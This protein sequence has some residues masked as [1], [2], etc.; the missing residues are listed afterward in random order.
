MQ[1]LRGSQRVWEAFAGL[2]QIIFDR[3]FKPYFSPVIHLRIFVYFHLINFYAA[4]ID[5]E[6]EAF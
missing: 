3:L 1:R 5:Y 6:L 2:G 4:I